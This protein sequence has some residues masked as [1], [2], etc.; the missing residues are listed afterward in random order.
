MKKIQILNVKNKNQQLIQII[1]QAVDL[2]P[3]SQIIWH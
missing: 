1:K 2:D 3:A